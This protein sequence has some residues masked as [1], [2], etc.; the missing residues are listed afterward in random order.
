MNHYAF[1]YYYECD[2]TLAED[3]ESRPHSP[4]RLQS[5]AP[6]RVSGIR[7]AR[8]QSHCLLL[9]NLKVGKIT[10]PPGPRLFTF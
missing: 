10:L 1:H 7:T 8:L 3:P 2:F 6:D 9:P 4:T 5:S